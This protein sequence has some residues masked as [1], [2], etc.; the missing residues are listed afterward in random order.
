MKEMTGEAILAQLQLVFDDL[1]L[2]RVSVTRELS[3]DQVPEWDSFQ[4]IALLVAIE[5]KLGLKFK[6]GETLHLRN[7]G[8]FVDLI[9]SK[10]AERAS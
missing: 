1:F 7:V 5:K 8:D 2:D 6:T 4:H 3:A 10:L 9:Q